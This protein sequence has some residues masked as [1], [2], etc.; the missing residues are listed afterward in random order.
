MIYKEIKRNNPQICGIRGEL[1]SAQLWNIQHIPLRFYNRI[2]SMGPVKF[3]ST[4]LGVIEQQGLN[5]Q[6]YGQYIASISIIA[7]Y[8]FFYQYRNV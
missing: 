4:M 5:T 2:A 1:W 8:C 7:L 3:Y 6:A